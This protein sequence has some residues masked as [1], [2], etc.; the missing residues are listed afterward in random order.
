MYRGIKIGEVGLGRFG[1]YFISIGGLGE[2]L[3]R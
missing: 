1:F 3:N 2:F